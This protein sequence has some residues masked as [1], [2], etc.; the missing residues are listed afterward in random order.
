M[1]GGG[2]ESLLLDIVAF[3]EDGNVD[4]NTFAVI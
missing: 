4:A 3:P 2:H 1:A